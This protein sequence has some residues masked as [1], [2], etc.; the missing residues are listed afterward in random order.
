MIIQ[1]LLFFMRFLQRNLLINVLKS[2]G[3]WLGIL[4]FSIVYI[5]YDFHTSFDSWRK[6]SDKMYMVAFINPGG[7]YMGSDKY[8][9]TSAVLAPEIKKQIPQ[10]E[11][12]GRVLETGEL[13]LRIGTEIFSSND[14]LAIDWE[15]AEMIGLKFL[16]G[17]L[18]SFKEP[19]GIILTKSESERLFGFE[20]PIG[21]EIIPESYKLLNAFKV[22]AVIEDVPENSMFNYNY[23]FNFESY[24]KDTNP[25]G[26]EQWGNR[27]YHTFLKVPDNSKI[28]TV[29]EL[30]TK[31]R[32][33]S[34]N[35]GEEES[36]FR[37]FLLPLEELHFTSGINFE[38]GNT[39]NKTNIDALFYIGI[40]ILII[41][42]FNVVNLSIAD[43]F[44]RKKEIGVRKSIGASRFSLMAQYMLESLLFV[45]VIMV[46]VLLSLY[47]ILPILN[48]FLDFNLSPF[49]NLSFI[50][51]IAILVITLSVVTSIYPAWILS[52]LKPSRV[53]NRANVD[54]GRAIS[55]RNFLVIL[56]FLMAG[57]L[58]VVTI[59]IYSQIDFLL[60][61][62]PGFS[63]NG[64][65]NVEIKDSKVRKD[66]DIRRQMKLRILENPN[67]SAA[68]YS[69]QL[70]H[71]IT[72]QNGRTWI[73]SK[74]NE[75][76]LSLY[77][78]IAEPE[79]IDIYDIEI[80]EGK[81]FENNYS[82]NK[83]SY[84]LNEKAIEEIGIE[85]IV[86]Q[87][88]LE[89]KDTVRVIG[90]MK[91]FHGLSMHQPIRPVRISME[92]TS[93]WNY[94]NISFTGDYRE[95]DAFI[96]NIYDE[97]N[98]HP[99]TSS[100]FSDNYERLY[101][102]ERRSR[103][104]ISIL[105][106]MAIFISCLGLFGLLLNAFE[107]RL[108]ELGIRK[109]LGGQVRHLGWILSRKLLSPIIIAWFISMPIAAYILREWMAAFA[110]KVELG[111]VAYIVSLIL[112][113][114]SLFLSLIYTLIRISKLNPVEILKSE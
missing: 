3:L 9:V 71:N 56:Q 66:I 83:T 17:N 46:I 4:I 79:M 70:P 62:D 16:R 45:S 63:R 60:T 102:E 19:K 82:S 43:S 69:S 68:S 48:S 99:Y 93:W 38:F 84:L 78:L 85:D 28:E 31:I 59:G 13:L 27:S 100:L 111:I 101:E 87:V 37:Y 104:L 65:L 8:G 86:G 5:V 92:E 106:I 50:L 47:L 55:V 54:I 61:T 77:T 24:L 81:A 90:V 96:K 26:P 21:R 18:D 114:F 80:I 73:D 11:Q 94:L 97:Y 2:I 98:D 67:I 32:N 10:V 112:L 23:F 72:S 74:G 107:S 51:V 40:V 15:I 20:D 53:F 14:G 58:M 75:K 108:K 89:N 22:V 36:K 88:F 39:V 1:A 25:K 42:C 49:T 6:D 109:T 110:F 41:S 76:Y 113:S 57:I 35:K 7:D 103:S 64:I 44:K 105:V 91:D 52:R 95:I 33:E 12:V 30:A 29:I 34:Q